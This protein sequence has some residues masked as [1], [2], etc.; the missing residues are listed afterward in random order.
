MEIRNLK[1]FATIARLQSFTKAADMLGY[2]QSTVTSQIQSLEEELGGILFERLGRKVTLT[3]N[4]EN[5]LLYAEQ[6]LKL[7]QAAKDVISNS[8]GTK[9]TLTIGTPESF[10]MNCMPE[11]LKKYRENYPD[12]EIKLR[13]GTCCEFHHFLQHN[14]VDLA[15]FLDQPIEDEHLV[16]HILFDEPVMII[17]SPAHPLAQKGRSITPQDLDGQSLVLTESG[18][19]YRERFEKTLAG[20]KVRSCYTL[21]VTSVEVIKRFTINNIGLTVLSRV[22]VEHELAAN[23]LVALPWNGP[24]FDVKAQLAYHK[25]KWVSPAMRA[26]IDLA[27]NMF[28]S[29]KV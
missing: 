1:T 29:Q 22:A 2:A 27:L 20:A 8:N 21:E 3:K 12:V 16:T 28:S 26:F 15:F 14:T 13:I 23:Q 9:G 5:L 19:V 6:I 18:C 4:G 17:A 11:L 25:R 7:N 24:S 10:C